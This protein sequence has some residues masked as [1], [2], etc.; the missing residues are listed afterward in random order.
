MDLA[1]NNED[2]RVTDII[3]G[4]SD[5]VV[6]YIGRDLM[7]TTHTEYRDGNGRNTMW[8][9]NWPILDAAD[10]ISG[11]VDPVLTVDDD[12]DDTWEAASTYSITLKWIKDKGEVY[13]KDKDCFP[14][15]TR[16]LKFVYTAGYKDRASIPRDLKMVVKKLVGFYRAQTSD[17]LGIRSIG[18]A[19]ESTT[20]DFDKWPAD[21]LAVLDRY[22][23]V[24]L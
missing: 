2:A 11:V 6:G 9:E 8:L 5:S 24:A 10:S 13:L 22:R 20:Y 19:N 18:I 1:Q 14:K 16:N 7:Q 12:G 21:V 3:N 23:R 4:V 15:G 17:K